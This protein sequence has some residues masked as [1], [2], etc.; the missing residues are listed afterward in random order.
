[1]KAMRTSTPGEELLELLHGQ[2]ALYRDL[3]SLASRQRGLVKLDDSGP[4]LTLLAERQK[5]V[6]ELG[7]CSR[8][9]APLQGHCRQTPSALSAEQRR[10]A[11]GLLQ[12]SADMLQSILKL[13]EE[14]ARTL[15]ARKSH[16]A[17][18]IQS[19]AAGQQAFRAY[20]PAAAGAA[21][22]SRTDESA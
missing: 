1:M 16:T 21:A 20:G 7:E 13:D 18:Q 15:E 3:H 17:R 14:D 9:L 5:I 12:A 2:L 11:E 6:A 19:L 8:R 22:F 10:Q 4:L